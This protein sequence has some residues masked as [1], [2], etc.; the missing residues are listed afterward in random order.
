MP[1]KYN[2]G[3][4]V[5]WEWKE[6]NGTPLKAT[7]SRIIDPSKTLYEV[8]TRDGSPRSATLSDLTPYK[9]GDF[10]KDSQLGKRKGA[11]GD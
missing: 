3:D 11:Q 9:T 6:V 5:W 10:T 1:R 7:I 4:K 8:T 2:I